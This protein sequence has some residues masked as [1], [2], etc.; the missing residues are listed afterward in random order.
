MKPSGQLLL[1]RVSRLQERGLGKTT[2]CTIALYW[3]L[4]HSVSFLT[5]PHECEPADL[6]QILGGDGKELRICYPGLGRGATVSVLS[7]LTPQ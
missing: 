4:F 7:V 1:L 5:G 2:P 6:L 3:K